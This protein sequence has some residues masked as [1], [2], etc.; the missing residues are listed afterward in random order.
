MNRALVRRAAVSDTL[1]AVP[2]VGGAVGSGGS[3]D[4]QSGE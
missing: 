2:G 3:N 1:P 4:P